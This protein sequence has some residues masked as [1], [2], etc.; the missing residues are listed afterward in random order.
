MQK[1]WRE[2]SQLLGQNKCG[3]NCTCAFQ[4][5]GRSIRTPAWQKIEVQ[6]YTQELS[7][8]DYPILFVT[9]VPH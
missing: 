4:I 8:G 2:G 9:Q 3:N 7:K 1:V 6:T 5:V